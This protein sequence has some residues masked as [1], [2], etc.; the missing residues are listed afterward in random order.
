MNRPKSRSK[1]SKVSL[2]RSQSCRSDMDLSDDNSSVHIS[3]RSGSDSPAND[4]NPSL[5]ADETGTLSD[6]TPSV[7][8]SGEI[9]KLRIRNGFKLNQYQSLHKGKHGELKSVASEVSISLRADNNNPINNQLTNLSKPTKLHKSALTP[10]EVPDN[11]SGLSSLVKNK[12]Q[13]VNLPPFEESIIEGFSIMAFNTAPEMELYARLMDK[14]EEP[15]NRRTSSRSAS[16]VVLNNT[17][18]RQRRCTP[19]SSVARGKKSTVPKSRGR[20]I[21][22]C[23]WAIE[24]PLRRVFDFSKATTPHLTHS[25]RKLTLL[26]KRVPCRHNSPTANGPDADTTTA[27]IK[28]SSST[29]GNDSKGDSVRL[30]PLHI[31]ITSPTSTASSGRKSGDEMVLRRNETKENG[32]Q[33][34]NGEAASA[35][36]AD[37]TFP[38][39]LPKNNS[40]TVAKTITTSSAPKRDLF[41]IAALT[42]VE[43][44]EE[45]PSLVKSSQEQH[46]SQTHP[47]QLLQSPQPRQNGHPLTPAQWLERLSSRGAEMTSNKG[48]IGVAEEE[49]R[50]LTHLLF[51]DRSFTEQVARLPPVAQIMAFYHQQQEQLRQQ[52]QRSQIPSSCSPSTAQSFA[53]TFNSQQN[54]L[55]TGVPPTAAM[56]P[57]APLTNKTFPP[58]PHPPLHFT[59]PVASAT[60]ATLTTATTTTNANPTSSAT[61]FPTPVNSASA[62]VTTPIHPSSL[63]HSPAFFNSTATVVA[64]ALAAGLRPTAPVF[65]GQTQSLSTGH[66][67]SAPSIS[68]AGTSIPPAPPSLSHHP[69]MPNPPHLSTLWCHHNLPRLQPPAPDFPYL[70]G[71][72]LHH[73]SVQLSNNPAHARKATPVVDAV[74]L[75][76]MAGGGNGVG[77]MERST[78]VRPTVPQSIL[79]FPNFWAHQRSPVAIATPIQQPQSQ[80]SP[81]ANRRLHQ[82]PRFRDLFRI[83]GVLSNRGATAHLRIC[84]HIM[85]DKTHGL[86]PINLSNPWWYVEPNPTLSQPKPRER[87]PPL[88]HLSHHQTLPRFPNYEQFMRTA[89]GGGNCAVAPLPAHPIAIDLTRSPPPHLTGLGMSSVRKPLHQEL[90]RP[91]DPATAAKFFQQHQQQQRQQQQRETELMMALKRRRVMPEGGSLVSPPLPTP[92]MQPPPQLLP[93]PH[94]QNGGIRMPLGFPFSPPHFRHPL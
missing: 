45:A 6:T 89:L 75:T 58:Q 11:S 1:R 46:Q 83:E 32:L 8:S 28:T 85:M 5:N 51:T 43:E 50:Q 64:A 73:P 66:L 69:F 87:P 44:R 52:Q 12:A 37:K 82:L 49:L 91:V 2:I 36:S 59:P 27:T 40:N 42:A 92:P 38:V 63:S 13:N 15:P 88:P 70:L 84:Y 53:N 26:I 80:P 65:Q 10:S 3:A 30:G 55:G 22:K 18:G 68:T 4:V 48:G 54:S 72:H 67:L 31:D 77:N 90:P 19:R 29:K 62:V 41:S 7:L 33:I 24:H 9:K 93:P 21:T 17:L 20:S 60:A 79:N 56:D 78:G 14:N 74:D 34:S 39:L 86:K 61:H 57:S 23:N 25:W 71:P 76:S 81:S 47:P 35:L 16:A 94:Y